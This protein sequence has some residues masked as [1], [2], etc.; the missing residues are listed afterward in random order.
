MSLSQ[1]RKLFVAVLFAALYSNAAVA[2]DTA[3]APAEE[4]AAR[5]SAHEAASVAIVVDTSRTARKRAGELRK[6]VAALI[7]NLTAEDEFC[8]YS[9][10]DKPVLVQDFTGDASVVLNASKRLRRDGR[11]A[12]FDT[13]AV[14]ADH[15][16]NDAA[17]ENIAI[18][19][20]VAGMDS[21]SKISPAT[22]EPSSRAKQPVALY[23]VATPGSDVALQETLQQL[24]FRT[25]GAAYFPPTAKQMIEASNA[26]GRQLRP[27]DPVDASSGATSRRGAKSK[28]PIATYKLLVV[29]SIPVVNSN[30]TTEFPGGDNLL[31]HR[32]LVSRLQ[33]A[34]LFSEV[35]DAG[36]TNAQTVPA[37]GSEPGE[38]LELLATIVGYRR[39]NRLRRQFTF[40]G[41]ARIKVQVILRD[42]ATAEPVLAFTEE[43]SASAGLFGGSNEQMQTRAIMTVV[44]KI[45]S[46]LRESR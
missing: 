30:E 32:V 19:V 5:A 39:G 20:F 12:L 31:L 7:T 16:R 38:K 29:R 10:S 6:S 15:L 3:D 43:G 42:A 8:V 27:G 13:I 21:A 41:A 46:R 25:R 26:V 37:T 2:Q 11:F 18:V 44:N 40:G 14:A 35:I 24:A 17:N 45:I 1:S 22:L 33:K 4:P 28:K 9:T 23:F 36:S 34:K